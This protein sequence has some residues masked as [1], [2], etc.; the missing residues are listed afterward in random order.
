M[1]HDKTSTEL[2]ANTKEIAAPAANLVAPSEDPVQQ[3]RWA[4]GT[5]WKI[6]SAADMPQLFG[7]GGWQDGASAFVHTSRNI[8]TEDAMTL[9]GMGERVM[10]VNEHEYKIGNTNN[11]FT[12]SQFKNG[13]SQ[14]EPRFELGGS[15]LAAGDYALRMDAYSNAYDETMQALGDIV[16]PKYKLDG[17]APP[18]QA[19]SRYNINP[20]LMGAKKG[21]PEGGQGYGEA[22]GEDPTP[23]EG[24]DL[25]YFYN[26][27]YADAGAQDAVNRNYDT[28]LRRQNTRNKQSKLLERQAQ[29]N[30]IMDAVNSAHESYANVL[31]EHFK[32]AYMDSDQRKEALDRFRTPTSKYLSNQVGVMDASRDLARSYH[33][34]KNRPTKLNGQL[35]GA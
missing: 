30:Q 35:V 13:L 18:D 25:S 8:Q 3:S 22:G 1:Q 31:K 9:N 16:C 15:Q 4:T 14:R 24:D 11:E 12:W 10:D 29:G 21:A 26:D 28:G 6:S 5:S 17:E 19:E 32:D 2:S 33:G 23:A 20:F 34:K 7:Y 27:G